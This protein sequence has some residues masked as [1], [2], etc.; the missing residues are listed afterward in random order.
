MQKEFNE[1]QHPSVV[2]KK[3]KKKGSKKAGMEGNFL[4]LIKGI[5]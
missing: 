2:K 5:F 1:T 4:K 3:K